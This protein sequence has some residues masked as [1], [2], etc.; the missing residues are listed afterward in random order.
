M[1]RNLIDLVLYGIFTLALVLA[2]TSSIV[3]LIGSNGDSIGSQIVTILVFLV[4]LVGCSFKL[5]RGILRLK[6]EGP[7]KSE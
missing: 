1:K 6:A 3:T 4:L 2:L 5:I 7:D